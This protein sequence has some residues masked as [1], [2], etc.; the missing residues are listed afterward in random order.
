MIDQAS[1]SMMSLVIDSVA[2]YGWKCTIIGRCSWPVRTS[3]SGASQGARKQQMAVVYAINESEIGRWHGTRSRRWAHRV[4]KWRW[5]MIQPILWEAVACLMFILFFSHFKHTFGYLQ[6]SSF[7]LPSRACS[8]V[9]YFTSNFCLI[10][11]MHF[12]SRV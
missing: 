9:E 3:L 4:G 7:T 5:L 8:Y 12:L 11:A 10:R 6:W 1:K 2:S